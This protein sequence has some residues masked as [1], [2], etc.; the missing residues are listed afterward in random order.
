LQGYFNIK[1]YKEFEAENRPEGW[2][3]WLTFVLSPAA[4]TPTTAMSTTRR[5][6]TK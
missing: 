5:M 3:V 6:Y 4:S 1:G 2:N